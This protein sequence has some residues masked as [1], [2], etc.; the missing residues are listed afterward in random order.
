[1]PLTTS[2]G[3]SDVPSTQTVVE[4]NAAIQP[5]ATDVLNTARAI[6]AAGTPAY[7]GQMTAGP[8][9]YQTQAWEGLAN[10]TLPTSM[11]TAASNLQ[12]IQ[13]KEQNLSFDPNKIQGYMNPYLESA[14]KPQIAEAKRQA[15]INLAPTMAKYTQAGGLGGSRA[16]I[17]SAEAARNLN[18]NLANITGTGYKTA[19]D[20]AAKLAQ[21]DTTLGLQGLQAATTANQAA[22]NIGAQQAQYGLSNLQALSAA[23]K[24]AQGL[25]Q[26][27]LNAQY[28]EFLR[29]L[30]YPMETLTSYSNIVRNVPGGTSSSTYGAKP[31]TLQSLVGTTSG[32]VQLQNNLK[33]AGL[34]GDALK[35][36]LKS[37]GV[38][39][40]KIPTE[41][42]NA[43]TEGQPG[44]G[45]RYFSDGTAIDPN[46]NYYYQGQQVYSSEAAGWDA[47]TGGDYGGQTTDTGGGG[48]ANVGDWYTGDSLVTDP[49][50]NSPDLNFD[51][52]P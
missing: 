36:A 19:Y 42:V 2:S 37:L 39:D 18:T 49:V 50:T 11:T 13:Q 43:A 25:D 8:S 40:D 31:S 17:A 41:V 32:I 14:L 45:W 46:G 35:N 10:L 30:K 51:N 6:N 33:A 48:D 29:Q 12:D 52:L 26:A 47:A 16:A 20:E 5:Y 28:N 22:G 44:Y 9:K 3:L 23:G 15:A 34:T 4:P 21:Y 24:E 7:T 38:T 27:A 1:M